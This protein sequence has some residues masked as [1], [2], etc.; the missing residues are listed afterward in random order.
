MKCKVASP[1]K[2]FIPKDLFIMLL[3]QL[4]SSERLDFWEK[5]AEEK[6]KV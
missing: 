6:G 2:R 5:R 1:K 3:I 4:F